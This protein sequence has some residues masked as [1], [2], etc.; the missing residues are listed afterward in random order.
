[1]K[2][3]YILVLVRMNMC[4]AHFSILKIRDDERGQGETDGQYTQSQ[5]PD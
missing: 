4:K 3:N 5:A 2:R 1:M